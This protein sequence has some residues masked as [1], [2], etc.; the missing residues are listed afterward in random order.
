M[1]EV[2][3]V[4]KSFGN[5]EVLK[6]VDLTVDKGEVISREDDEHDAHLL[7]HLDPADL[8]RFERRRRVAASAA[9]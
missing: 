9:S 5:L 1:I 3:N 6:G 8:A 2:K 7:V 4:H